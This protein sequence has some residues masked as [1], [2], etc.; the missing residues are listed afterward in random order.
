MIKNPTITDRI[1]VY[2]C[3]G[4]ISIPLKLWKGQI[5]K[6]RREGFHI[7]IKSSTN[8]R[9]E[10]SCIISWKHPHGD[11]AAYMLSVTINALTKNLQNY[12]YLCLMS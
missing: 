9:G 12:H 2:A 10:F 11:Q 6:L 3:D 5:D 4:R 1:E 8:R 7:F